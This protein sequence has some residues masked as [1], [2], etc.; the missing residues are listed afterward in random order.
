[1]STSPESPDLV[2]EKM[3]DFYS[4]FSKKTSDFYK[5]NQPK[6]ADISPTL[7]LQNSKLV[8]QSTNSRNMLFKTALNDRDSTE[9]RS[10]VT[11]LFGANN[12]VIP[13]RSAIKEV[14]SRSRSNRRVINLDPEYQLHRLAY[15][16]TKT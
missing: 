9:L 15:S 10:E 16:V 4:M 1:M 2:V 14:S 5:E 13:R 8:R 6:S 12:I 11:G 3:C 7:P